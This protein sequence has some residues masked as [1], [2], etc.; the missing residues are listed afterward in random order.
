MD[1]SL[2]QDLS[3]KL[4]ITVKQVRFTAH[5][6]T[7]YSSIP[8]IARYRKEHT[9]GLDENQII[10]IRDSL[11][12]FSEFKERQ[13]KIL[14]SLLQRKLLTDKLKEKIKTAESLTQL[15]DLYRPFKQKKLT[16]G[17]L[18]KEKGL[19]PL[20]LKLMEQLPGVIPSVAADL[21]IESG[22]QAESYQEALALAR[23]F[24][25]EKV[26]EN[27][28]ARELLRKLYQEEAGLRIRSNDP[29][30]DKKYK[31]NLNKFIKITQIP[32]HRFFIW[33]RYAKKDKIIMEITPKL[34]KALDILRKLFIVN[35]SLSAQE[36]DKALVDS[37]TRLIYPSLQKEIL[38]E[39]KKRADAQA[40]P[41]FAQNFR[42]LLMTPPVR[43][44]VVLG[45]KP[46][47]KGGFA[48]AALSPTGEHLGDI[49]AFPQTVDNPVYYQYKY[50]QKINSVDLPESQ[51][52]ITSLAGS[53]WESVVGPKKKAPGL[54]ENSVDQPERL[55]GFWQTAV[56]LVEKVEGQRENLQDQEENFDDWPEENLQ[57]PEENFDYWPEENLQDPEENF[58][59]WP[60]ENLQD[61]EENLA[62]W[63]EE[64]LQ[65]QEENFDD[66]P[67][68][69]AQD[70][71][72]NLDDWSEE[73][74]FGLGEK[75]DDLEDY[76][77][78]QDQE[79]QEQSENPEDFSGEKAAG[80]GNNFID[81]PKKPKDH[82]YAAAASW[83]YVD[84]PDSNDQGDQAY[85][86]KIKKTTISK[87]TRYK[88]PRLKST[89]AAKKAVLDII[90][91]FKIDLVVVGNGVGGRQTFNFIKSLDGLPEN[92]QMVMI[93]ESGT[94]RYSASPKAKAEYPSLSRGTLVAI[95]LGRRLIDPMAELVKMNPKA[96]GI[97]QFQHDV[98]KVALKRSLDDTVASC[99]NRVGVELNT[100]SEKLLSYVAGLG[101]N[102]PKP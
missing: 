42:D 12:V 53:L 65:D 16:R 95:S 85:Y 14:K 58:D 8:F 72:E 86:R 69:K 52:E 25:A 94:T 35:S 88:K 19:G 2:A 84:D 98:D 44:K 83:E 54:T 62:D 7:R 92:L 71:A 5:L 61:Q 30:K 23:D 63:P 38:L 41:F 97:G 49:M 93:D 6:L 80:Q 17:R 11:R 28:T 33:R 15:D 55:D 101:E 10:A 96:L 37:Y 26:Y 48:M 59:D 79:A 36:V 3:K 24:L 1:D 99:V 74:A 67:E 87:K 50:G 68:E 34:S 46:Y 60:E 78:D 39:L 57:D 91:R 76:F 82:V 45:V 13:E 22:A 70:P 47:P 66:W 77:E 29:I 9:G 20:A 56:S 43:G 27:I 90:N 51:D 73:Q 64:N 18:A 40:I 31:N 100:A 102:G 32:P 89:A 4:N 81:Q 75:S 21:A